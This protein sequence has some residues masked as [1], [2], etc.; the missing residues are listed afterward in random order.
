MSLALVAGP[1]PT[2]T[3]RPS[4]AHL[5]SAYMILAHKLPNQVL[6]LIDRLDGPGAHFFV[7]ISKNADPGFYES[8][9]R[10]VARR[11]NVSL[12]ERQWVHWGHFGLAKALFAAIE[13]AVQDGVRLDYLTVL[14]G[15][16]YP[17]GGRRLIEETLGKHRGN[18]LM[19]VR[20]IPS[21][22][23]GQGGLERFR[24]HHLRLAGREVRFPPFSR[25]D[26][27]LGQAARTMGGIRSMPNGMEPYGGSSWVS[28]TYEAVE[29]LFEFSRSPFGRRTLR[30]FSTVLHPEE[31]VCQT[32]LMNSELSDR[33]YSRNFRYIDWT[34]HPKHPQVLTVQDYDRIV[35]SG[36][37]LA[38]KFDET[39]CTAIMDALDQVPLGVHD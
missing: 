21:E 25:R 19:E 29:Y 36:A 28:L 18:T 5:R 11:S 35:E 38:R 16:D 23:W 33:V 10:D 32:I 8:I 37:F 12:V 34:S 2:P 24:I 9:S 39:V 6:R 26:D 15:Q 31:M 13:M 14:S 3:A 1:G 30:F 27:W 22:I 7:H 17:V 20:R 4:V